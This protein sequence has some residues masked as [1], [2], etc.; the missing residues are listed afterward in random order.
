MKTRLAVLA[1]LAAAA[2]A[3]FAQSA[4]VQSTTTTSVAVVPATISP[5]TDWPMRDGVIAAAPA[6]H[7]VVVPA[8]AA[9][10]SSTAVM[11]AGAAPVVQYYFNVPRDIQTRDEFQ[12]WRRLM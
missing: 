11:G 10:P 3:A 1:A 2:P 12:R 4:T 8:G 6:I 5:V 7:T 9:G